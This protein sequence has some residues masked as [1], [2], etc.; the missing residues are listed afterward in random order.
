MYDKID[1][2]PD[3][4]GEEEGE[5]V[6]VLAVTHTTSFRRYLVLTRISFNDAG[7]SKSFNVSLT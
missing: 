1:W 2:R 4:F 7:W 6:K 5:R 3:Q